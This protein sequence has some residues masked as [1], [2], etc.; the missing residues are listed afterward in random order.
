MDIR[1]F[2]GK[3]ETP[4][5]NVST[6]LPHNS[7]TITVNGGVREFF[8]GPPRLFSRQK[9]QGLHPHLM[10]TMQDAENESAAAAQRGSNTS[11]PPPP[12]RKRTPSPPLI[13][14]NFDGIRKILIFDTETTGLPPAGMDPKRPNTVNLALVPHITQ[15]SFVIYD[16]VEETFTHLFNEYIDI[17]DSIHIS[18]LITD[19]TG[20]DRDVLDAKGIP[21][22]FALSVFLQS[23][24]HC[25]CIVGHNITFDMKMIGYE[26]MRNGFCQKGVFDHLQMCCTMKMGQPI[27]KLPS[28]R[29]PNLLKPP[30]LIELHSHLFDEPVENLHNSIVDVL[31]CFRCFVKMAYN[32]HIPIHIFNEIVQFELNDDTLGQEQEQRV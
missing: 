28:P 21:M 23:I 31:V 14:P 4:H 9:I 20:I 3:T 18:D 16:T 19:I 11:H 6:I 1:E 8:G 27:C 2:F 32:K 25:D 22:F 7:N 30:K 17:H 26:M 5:T 24:K 15:L 29:F 12:F 13:P 10:M